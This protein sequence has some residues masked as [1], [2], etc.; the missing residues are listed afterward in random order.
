M[1]K[2]VNNETGEVKTKPE[3]VAHFS[4]MSLP[5]VWSVEV[6]ES[7]NLRQ[8]IPT[9]KPVANAHEVIVGGDP[10]KNANGDWVET[11]SLE[12]MFR[13]YTDD[14]GV[15][16][17]VEAQI[18]SYDET[19]RNEASKAKRQ[20]RDKKLAE[21]DWWA[22][23]DVTMTDEQRQYRQALRDITTHENWPNLSEHDW[24]VKP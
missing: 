5:K 12:P 24:P 9:P 7:L 22:C 14:D 4:H 2:F 20:E 3:W 13:E 6:L 23:S 21:T 19:L 16:H 18:T 8:V 11:W 1:T 17:T 15:V 10:V